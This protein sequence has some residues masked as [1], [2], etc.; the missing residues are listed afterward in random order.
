MKEFFE[1]YIEKTKRQLQ[2]SLFNFP[3]D[4]YE[5]KIL[6][7][8]PWKEEESS[9]GEV[10]KRS[11]GKHS[12]RNFTDSFGCRLFYLFDLQVSSIEMQ[13]RQKSYK[14]TAVSFSQFETP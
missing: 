10:L 13:E 11:F 6:T 4:L 2:E 8:L 12:L 7:L 1:S 3:S 5:I 14:Q 9:L